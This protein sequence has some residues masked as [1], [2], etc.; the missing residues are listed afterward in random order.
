MSLGWSARSDAWRLGAIA[1]AGAVAVL[2][3]WMLLNLTRFEEPVL[4][5][6]NDGLTLAGANCDATYRGEFKGGWVIDPCVLQGYATLDAAKPGDEPPAPF[7]QDPCTDT[8][9]RRL[10]CLDPSEVSKVLRDQGVEY[11]KDHPGDLP[12]VILARNGRVWGFYG[13]GQAAEVGILEGREPWATRAGFVFTWV[14]LPLSVAGMVLLRRRG[15]TIVPFVAS[16]AIV[17]IAS[18]AFTGLVSRFRV[19]WDVAACLLAAVAIVH[20][21]DRRRAPVDE[22]PADPA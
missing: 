10:P 17:V 21:L 3:P 19:P 7:G 4:I 14:L 12:G 11:I 18:S 6:T 2:G 22:A 8:L 9:Q 13:M 20:L 1:T 15:T 5:S 16:L